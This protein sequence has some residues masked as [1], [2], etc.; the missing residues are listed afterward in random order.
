M[1][2]Q[3]T[4]KPP[5][6]LM[7]RAES[8]RGTT[9]IYC[10]LTITALWVKNIFTQCNNEHNTAVPTLL[11]ISE[12]QLRKV[13]QKI[14]GSACTNRRFSVPALFSYFFSST[15][16]IELY[17][18]SRSSQGFPSKLFFLAKFNISSA[19]C[20]VNGVIWLPPIKRANSCFSTFKI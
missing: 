8:T 6:F 4:K 20:N 11:K 19:F 12:Q 14:A 2:I 15:P 5:A 7:Q 3:G 9:S 17:R 1:N 18:M 16:M 10:D 13:F